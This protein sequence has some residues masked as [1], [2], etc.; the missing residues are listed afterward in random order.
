[1]LDEILEGLEGFLTSTM[2]PIALLAVR[3]VTPV[4]ALYV[5]WR[6]YTSFKKGLRRKAPVIM[7]VDILHQIKFPILYW[8]NSIGRS[9]SCDIMLPDA[10]VSRDHAVLMRRASGWMICDTESRSGVYVNGQKIR[11][12]AVVNLNDDIVVGNTALTLKSTDGTAQK[13]GR[14]FRGFSADAASPSKL[15]FICSLT[16]LLMAIQLCFSGKELQLEPLIL[17]AKIAAISWGFFFVSILGLRR[18]SFEIETVGLLLSGIGIFVLSGIGMNLNTQLISV[19]VGILFFNFLIWFLSNADRVEQF[20][21]WIGGGAIFAFVL[22]LALAR[23]SFGA[24]NW[25]YIGNFSIQPSEFIKIA[26]VIFG[27]ATLDRLQTKKSVTT[28]LIFTGICMGA[29]FLINDFGTALLFYIC[30]VI[31]AFMR[32]G[33]FRTVIL[34]LAT[35]AIGIFG[36]SYILTNMPH[37]AARFA[38][39]GHIWESP[40][41]GGYQQT[42][43]LTYLASGGLFGV[44]LGKGYLWNIPAAE[45]DCTFAILCEEIGFVMAAV[46]LFAIVMFV[47]Y[48]RSDVTRSRSTLYSITSCATAGLLLFQTFLH[49]FGSTDIVPFTGVTLPFVSHGGSSMMA[50]WGLIAFLKASD[51]RTYAAK[52]MTRKNMREN[53][54]REKF[55]TVRQQR[56]GQRTERDRFERYS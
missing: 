38:N 49:V 16:H 54:K 28:F 4:F 3:I 44:G 41:D 23:T 46:V 14:I 35:V 6:C 8:E 2:L 32:S 27:A 26:F 36:V 51:E 22:N 42:R 7:L 47:F 48:A 31:I 56:R 10:G 19:V 11:E 29:L 55:E 13:Q 20:R 30:F 18:V 25:I 52:R 5:I 50:V 53:E 34:I 45:S 24:K 12:K 43:A 15:M 21:M 40:Y 1:L 33:S 17:F 39:W 9:K 37:V